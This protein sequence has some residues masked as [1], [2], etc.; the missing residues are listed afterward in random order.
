MNRYIQVTPFDAYI[1]TSMGRRAR[2][3]ENVSQ[4]WTWL[5]VHSDTPHAALAYEALEQLAPGYVVADLHGMAIPIV[6]PA[7][8]LGPK[9]LEEVHL[10]IH[11]ALGAIRDAI[12]SH[13][14]NSSDS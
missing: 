12:K 10:Q 8:V 1:S 5:R 2:P 14:P 9:M 7:G 4:R 13:H 11:D 6:I 3:D